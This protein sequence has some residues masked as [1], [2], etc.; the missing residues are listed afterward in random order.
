MEEKVVRK[1]DDKF[2]KKFVYKELIQMWFVSPVPN[3]EIYNKYSFHYA[4]DTNQ[5]PVSRISRI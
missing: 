1:E 4:E 5:I 2:A 3:S